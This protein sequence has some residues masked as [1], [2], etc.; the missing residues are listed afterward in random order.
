MALRVI[1]ADDDREWLS[2]SI[3]ILNPE[4]QVIAT[5]SDGKSALEYIR[6]LRPDVAIVDLQMPGLNGIE[7]ARKTIDCQPHPAVVICS[8]ESDPEIIAHA[9]H[10]G[11]LA[12]VLKSRLATDLI[13]AVRSVAAGKQFVSPT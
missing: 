3:A 11:A 4:V 5:A 12:Y 10:A 13:P 6:K 2:Q 8:V 1:V 7:L 9:L